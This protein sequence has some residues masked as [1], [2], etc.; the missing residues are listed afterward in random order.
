[1]D[2]P[3]VGAPVVAEDLAGLPEREGQEPLLAAGE[4]QDDH[5]VAEAGPAPGVQEQPGP[6]GGDGQARA[7]GPGQ[8]GGGTAA[9]RHPVGPG[10]PAGAGQAV[11]DPGAV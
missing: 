9:E 1:G 10:L 5:P 2:L 6:V 8:L 3:A 7:G 4:I 11:V